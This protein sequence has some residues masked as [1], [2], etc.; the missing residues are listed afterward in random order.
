[1]RTQRSGSHGKATRSEGSELCLTCEANDPKLV[2]SSPPFSEPMEKLTERIDRMT[3]EQKKQLR[4]GVLYIGLLVM[5]CLLLIA[6][7]TA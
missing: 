2:W 1:M 6:G 4:R 5:I 3:R 7:L